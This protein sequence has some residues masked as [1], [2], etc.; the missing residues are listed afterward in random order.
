MAGA[1][2]W[3]FLNL[4]Q[5][6]EEG[7]V[8]AAGPLAT[9]SGGIATVTGDAVV[10]QAIVMLLS[11]RPGERVM[12]PDYGC[13]L[14]RLLFNGNDATTA[15]LAIHYVGQALRRFEPRID[16]VRLV[17]GPAPDDATGSVLEVQLDYRVRVNQRRET[18]TLGLD[19]AGRG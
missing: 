11:T 10:R 8:F 13:P 4:G 1:S 6:A 19:L 18:L 3:R 2:G 7:A 17:A 5:G 16:V 9:A 12:R 14:N 15:G